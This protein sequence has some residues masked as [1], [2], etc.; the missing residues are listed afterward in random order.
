MRKDIS[1]LERNQA[2]RLAD[3]GSRLR[4]T[5]EDH[6]LTLEQ[7]AEQ[8]MI[9]ARLL[10]ALENGKLHQ[11][12]EPVYIRGFIKRYAEVLGLNGAELSHAFPIESTIRVVGSGAAW[13]SSP[14]AQLRPIH[15]YAAYV[16]L[17]VAA[18]SGLSYLMNRS[19]SWVTGRDY[20]EQSAPSSSPG[21][22]S[23]G[24]SRQPNATLSAGASPVGNTTVT[25]PSE[26]GK[27][28][29]VD[30][31]LTAQS[32]LRVDIDGKTAFQGILPEGTQKT[33][34]ADSTVKVRAGNA[35]AVM[36]A[37]NN[38]QAQR[39]GAPGAVE[40]VIFSVPQQAASLPTT[41]TSS[42]IR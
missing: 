25:V 6:L 12:P 16:L 30:V 15:L 36:V 11:L 27:P 34:T 32:W 28:V 40:E 18:V 9:Q 26:P 10:R 38:G 14:A 5:R 22:K 2:E 41:D 31:T 39:M 24:T 8:T 29:R 17:I 7:V 1:Q 35:G 37:Y 20:M 23:P 3:I 13:K 42:S 33:W 19:T 21:V 4:Q